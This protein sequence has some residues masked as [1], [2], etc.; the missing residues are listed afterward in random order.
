MCKRIHAST[1][2]FKQIEWWLFQLGHKVVPSYIF[3]GQ[4][5]TTASPKL[6]YDMLVWY[7]K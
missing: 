7:K 5:K 3:Q 4:Y 6:V 2:S 1:P